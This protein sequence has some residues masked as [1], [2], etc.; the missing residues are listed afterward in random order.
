MTIEQARTRALAKP[1]GVSDLRP[2]NYESH[3]GNTIGEIWYERANTSVLDSSLLLKLIFTSQPLSIQVHPDDEF[4]HSIGLPRGK[5]EVWYV[6]SAGPDAKVALGLKKTITQQQLSSALEDGSIAE[7]V[8]WRNVSSNDIIYVPAGT[9][10]AIGAGLVIAELQQRSDATFRLF[11][12][13]RNRELHFD[14]AK[15]VAKPGPALFQ[16]QPKQICTERTLLVS[17]PHFTFERIKLGQH[18]DWTLEVPARIGF[19]LSAAAR[20]PIHLM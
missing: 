18:S 8:E 12:Y 17:C 4:A 9:I 19:W 15:A 6:I 14:N 16:I 13:A 5:S 1:W 20:A 10:H 7:L 3:N 11:D 2:W